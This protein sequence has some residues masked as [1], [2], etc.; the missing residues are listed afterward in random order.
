[1][2]NKHWSEFWKGGSTTTFGSKY[3]D[4]Y[5]KDI[6]DF[7]NGIFTSEPNGAKIHD[8]AAGSGAIARLAKKFSNDKNK[9]FKI[10]AN[11]YA[12]INFDEN[13]SLGKDIRGIK[14]YPETASEKLPI[15]DQSIDLIMSQ[16]G[17]EYSSCEQTV[18]EILRILK[19]NG[20]FVAITH[21]QL[22]ELIQESDKNL[23]FL[24]SLD[25]DYDY[26][27]TLNKFAFELGDVRNKNEVSQLQYNSQLEKLRLKVNDI[28]DGILGKFPEEFF[29]TENMAYIQ[30]LFKDRIIGSRDERV[31]YSQFIYKQN[32]NNMERLEAMVNSSYDDQ[33]I[34]K[35]KQLLASYG[36]L[37][38]S[39]F[40][41]SEQ[42]NLGTIIFFTKK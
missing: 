35:L 36:E 34:K 30:S 39:D 37:E 18:I 23:K 1:M 25:R 8:L 17:F 20:R 38:L 9:L 6:A 4:N 14:F 15:T 40:I 24:K 7:W 22:S 26:H 2:A 27:K 13:T 42:R 11:D 28:L 33:K 3:K 5:D 31:S 29:Q 32:K 12:E 19:S 16:Y 10:S 21:S 41:D